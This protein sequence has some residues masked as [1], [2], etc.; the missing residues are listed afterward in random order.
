MSSFD[1]RALLTARD[2]HLF[3]PGH[4]RILSLDGGGVRGAI[5][6]AYLERMEKL[7]EEIEGKPVLLGD[8]FD[9]IGGT[10]TGAI[11]GTGLAL[12]YRAA[13]LCDFYRA[14]GPRVFQRS[15]W[16]LRGLR[17][18][19]DSRRL[20][21]ELRSI[22]G[23]RALDSEDLRTGL[24]IVTKRLDTGSTWIVMNNPRSRYWESPEDGSFIGNRYFPLVNVVRASTAAPNYFDPEPIQIIEGTQPGLF[25]DGGVSPHNSP[26]LHLFMVAALP[27]YGLCW[28]LGAENISVISV[29][30][31]SFRHRIQLDELP[32]LRTLGI[33]LHALTAQVSDA[34]QLVDMLMSWLGNSPMSWP[35]NSELGDLG[36]VSPPFDQPLFNFLRYDVKLETDWLARELGVSV[37]GRTV[38]AYRRL[39]APEN[40]PAIYELGVRAAERQ[41]RREHLELATG[42][43]QSAAPV[44]ATGP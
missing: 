18:R 24:C 40:I 4:K 35:I 7:I 26:A 14:L 31:G 17:A 21:E 33:A 37:D 1:K 27:P 23:A 9:L 38:S 15:M 44:V 39:D 42:R 25:V 29:G 30:T 34:Q 13:D 19:F 20:T 3:G 36:R 22:I 6:L 2:R 12:G 11:I 28:P 43:S 41:V 16:R 32:L 5:T 8:W 10:S